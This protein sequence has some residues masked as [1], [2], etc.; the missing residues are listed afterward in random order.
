MPIIFPNLTLMR[1]SPATEML[2]AFLARTELGHLALRQK[3]INGQCHATGHSR[4]GSS[5]WSPDPQW[6]L[7]PVTCCQGP[8]TVPY[9]RRDQ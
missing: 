6:T 7:L 4:T 8:E 2:S 5:M 1:P 9:A 3:H